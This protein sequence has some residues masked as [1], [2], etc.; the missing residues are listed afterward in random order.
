VGVGWRLQSLQRTRVPGWF[1]A[2][3]PG[4]WAYLPGWKRAAVRW[5]AVAAAA[6][7]LTRPLVTGAVL[8]WVAVIAGCALAPGTG[9]G[10]MSVR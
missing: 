4:R 7:L 5:A 6:G 1:T 10:G 8:G 2:A 9:G 3:E